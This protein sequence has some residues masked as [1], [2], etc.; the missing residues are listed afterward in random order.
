MWRALPTLATGF[1]GTYAGAG[2]AFVAKISTTG[3]PALVY[4]NYLGGSG[5]D[6][7]DAIATD[8]SGKAYVTGNTESSDFPQLS[9]LSA[10]DGGTDHGGIDAFV[11][12]Y[13]SNGQQ[14]IFSTYLGG[15]LDDKGLGIGLDSSGNIY[16]AGE[17][18]STNFPYRER[19]PGR[20]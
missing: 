18:Q 5:F 20:R 11:T 10:P 3:T 6:Q 17:T 14:R 4:A 15:D 8:G 7:A 12:A 2:D 13:T 16:V 9:G 1:S 19:I